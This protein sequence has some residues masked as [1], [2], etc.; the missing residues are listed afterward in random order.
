[1]ANITV[2]SE[3]DHTS[4]G[5]DADTSAARPR[6]I[7]SA[8]LD[9]VKFD[10]HVARDGSIDPVDKALYAALSSF[11]DPQDRATDPDG[12]DAP[13]RAVLAACI[14]RSVDTVD[15]ATKRLEQRGL[16]RVERRVDPDRP[17]CHLP[18]VYELCDHEMWD[19]RAAARTK[20]RKAARKAKATSAPPEASN[21]ATPGRT[22]A[23]TPGRTGAATPSRTDAAVL[24]PSKKEVKNPP[25][26]PV[27]HP[28]R[29]DAAGVRTA[30]GEGEDFAQDDKRPDVDGA[31]VA[32][33]LRMRDD[34][35]RS[36][37]VKALRHPKVA[38]RPAELVA[39]AF[40]IVAGDD[41]TDSPGRL[42]AAGPWWAEAARTT[43]PKRPTLP[44]RC[45]DVR[46]DANVPHDRML[47]DDQGRASR[48]PICHPAVLTGARS[49]TTPAEEEITP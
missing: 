25:N 28:Q 46:H 20:A 22:D 49:P 37:V 29:S 30:E 31:L 35:V 26:P 43:R 23:A 7:R 40:R 21:A 16:I 15:R 27:T 36:D 45:D 38:R 39:A 12:C 34:W 9:W 19:E 24:L 10:A 6:V 3:P 18:S 4:A 47:Y 17:K 13:T 1:M 14:G 32:E 41:T 44:D 42:A 48:C 5:P 33:I 2:V 11:A 8:G